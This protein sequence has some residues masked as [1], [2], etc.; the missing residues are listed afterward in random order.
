MKIAICDDELH[1]REYLL[2]EARNVLANLGID[3]CEIE[4]FSN[5][6]G[7]LDQYDNGQAPFDLVFLDIKMDGID[8]MNAARLIRKYDEK[9]YI[10][11]ITS[12]AEYVFRGYE[13]KA[14]RYILK[15]ELKYS[16]G[17]VL[18]TVL[19]EIK[20][21]G[22][23]NSFTFT[24]NGDTVSLPL[25]S[26]IYFESDRRV[27]KIHSK[28]GEYKTYDKLDNIIKIVEDKD[29]VRCHQSYIV[30]AREIREFKGSSVTLNDGTDLPVSKKYQKSTN[31]AMLW[32]IR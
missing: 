32:A 13:V 12:S 14:Y 2:D 29:F 27:A 17:S 7:L 3:D 16:F 19:D 8:G 18:R 20:N 31:E 4:T 1:I 23:D 5:A 24:F 22:I 28:K 30:N 10:V 6:E 15:T 21:T 9:V 25:S 11:F 26:I